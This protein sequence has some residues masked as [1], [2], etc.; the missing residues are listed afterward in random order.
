MKPS[1]LIRI[2]QQVLL[3]VPVLSAAVLLFA[4]CGSAGS[5]EPGGESSE[6]DFFGAEAGADRSREPASPPPDEQLTGR[7]TSVTWTRWTKGEAQKTLRPHATHVCGLSMV[8]GQFKTDTNVRITR[9]GANWVM[10]GANAAA[11]TLQME[12]VCAPHSAFRVNAGR[13]VTSTDSFGAVNTTNNSEKTVAMPARTAP[14][15]TGI[16]GHFEGGGERARTTFVPTLQAKKGTQSG[17][18]AAYATALSFG[19]PIGESVFVT[20]ENTSR[21]ESS[22]PVIIGCDGSADFCTN[23]KIIAQ[24]GQSFC[25]LSS[26]SGDFNGADEWIQV[27]PRFAD[28]TWRM[29]SFANSGTGVFGRAECV[30][31]NQVHQVVN[32]PR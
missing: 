20:D 7:Q 16:W 10:G 4:A 29:K 18:L 25:Y 24:L 32:P 12:A 28:G 5:D 19:L 27:Y 23:G 21:N 9:S 13:T 30:E 26:V 31:L 2:S 15:L 22:I 3:G 6:H 17:A 11:N 14:V 8:R 1:P